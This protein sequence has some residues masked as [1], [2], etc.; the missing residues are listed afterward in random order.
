MK[1][2]HFVIKFRSNYYNF[3]LVI[4]EIIKQ[5]QPEDRIERYLE[6]FDNRV[7]SHD[8]DDDVEVEFHSIKRKIII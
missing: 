7:P 3:F 5:F 6:F 2:K 1:L 8:S 4:A